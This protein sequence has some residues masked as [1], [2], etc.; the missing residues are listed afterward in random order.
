[1]FNA[2]FVQKAD[3]FE[4]VYG[5]SARKKI[6]SRVNILG[7][8]IL[9]GGLDARTKDL[10]AADFVFTGWGAP[11]IEELLLRCPHLKAIFFA[12]GTASYMLS[13]EAWERGIQI[14]SS[15]VANAVP[16]AEYSLAAILLG[17]KGGWRA[18]SDFKLSRR[19]LRRTDVPGA[20]QSTVGLISCGAIARELLRLLRGFDL[21]AIVYDPF[22][23]DDEIRSL[24]GEPSELDELFEIADVVSLHS[25]ELEETRGMITGHHLGSMKEGATFINTARGSI[26]NEADLCRVAARRPD[27]QFV[28][29]VVCPEPPLENS[30]LFDLPNVIVTPHIAGA[31]G[32]EC[33]RMGEYMVEELER[34]L[35]GEPLR[36]IITPDLAARSIHRPHFM[37]RPLAIS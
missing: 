29:D 20:Y 32:G 37:K 34:Y 13:P 30:P 7:P 22:L 16:V 12:G 4:R 35:E 14:S 21:K 3:F 31:M 15:Y 2:V 27:L 28:L 10:A 25:P 33:E 11:G 8:L 18:I 36:W 24:G 5:E 26:V 23:S 6:A 9:P 19:Y 17:L 1:L